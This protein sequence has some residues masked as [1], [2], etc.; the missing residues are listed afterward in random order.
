MD[1]GFPNEK[2]MVS[3]FTVGKFSQS[4]QV[5]KRSLDYN[6]IKK[7]IMT[8]VVAL[9]GIVVIFTLWLLA[10]N[11]GVSMAKDR[12]IM[13]GVRLNLQTA[14]TSRGLVEYDMYGTAGPVVLSIHGGFGGADQGRLFASWLQDNGFRILSP[15]RPGYLGTPLESGKTYFEQADLLAAL[16]DYLK[17]DKVGLLAYSAGSPVAYSFAARYPDRVWVL[18][19]WMGSADMRPRAPLTQPCKRLL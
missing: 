4:T 13:P 15:S 8:V 5:S 18:C 2:G 19:R 16:L 6:G 14:T 17:I 7:T 1:A 10:W 3:M 12:Q 9:I 11:D